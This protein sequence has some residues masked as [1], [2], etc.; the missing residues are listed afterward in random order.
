MSLFGTL[1]NKIFGAAPAHAET[2]TVE[3]T[4]APAASAGPNDKVV[5]AVVAV[6]DAARSVQGAAS[7]A[8]AAAV[9]L[10]SVDIAKILDGM[11][12]KQ[13][14]KLNWRQSIVDLMKLVGM[15]SSQTARKE[16]AKELHYTGD[17]NDS[18]A[19]NIWLHK[20]V[21]G[22]IAANGG[23]LPEDIKH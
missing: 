21:M 5:E 2:V 12:A 7:T 19:M 9:T 18:A 17:P 20:Q 8:A 4:S 11:N 14:Q 15:D 1:M 6:T 10:A 22:K 23:K 16:L 3:T 13:A